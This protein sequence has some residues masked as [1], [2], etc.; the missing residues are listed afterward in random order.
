LKITKHS[1]QY[2]GTT[3]ALQEQRY[4]QY[5]DLIDGVLNNKIAL[6]HSLHHSLK[7]YEEAILATY[8]Y[9]NSS[10]KAMFATVFN[11]AKQDKEK[12]GLDLVRE[13][14]DICKPKTNDQFDDI[15]SQLSLVKFLRGD[16]E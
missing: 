6:P 10:I 14:F 11:D 8:H 15:F 9:E 7:R 13:Y 2:F 16:R 1:G 12:R 4:E 5:K 3:L